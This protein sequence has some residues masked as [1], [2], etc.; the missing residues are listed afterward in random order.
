VLVY[1]A[2]AQGQARRAPQPPTE[3]RVTDKVRTE[4]DRDVLDIAVGVAQL[5]TAAVALIGIPLLI[6]QVRSAADAQRDQ[7][8]ALEAQ[9]DSV[10]QQRKDQR[11]Q[12]TRGFQEHCSSRDFL[13]KA[14]L[15]LSFLTT[16]GGDGWAADCVAKVQAWETR[17][18]AEEECLPRTPRDDA[19]PQAR[20]NDISHLMAFFE[21]FGAAYN[22][23]EL[24]KDVVIDSFAV[25]PLQ[26]FMTSWW[27]V[28]WRRKGE[29]FS[30]A[31]VAAQFEKLVRDMRRLSPVV[32]DRYLDELRGGI[33]CLPRPSR[34][35]AAER[36]EEGRRLSTLL[37]NGQ[38]RL[39]AV[40]DLTTAAAP[41]GATQW[42][43]IFVP[44]SLDHD[45][46][47]IRIYRQVKELEP[48]LAEL[49]V[50]TVERALA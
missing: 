4:S 9:R 11:S 5:V 43:L 49:D 25:I 31:A 27:F 46:R 10:E 47:H 22:H 17:S 12:R 36:W 40:L 7:R 42:Q 16:E 33:L 41:S 2:P 48:V 35:A 23:D 14:S 30:E 34:H 38:D 28:C 18:H 21:D 32:G 39:D 1:A 13:E 20:V 45:E 19:A 50:D 44:D 15:G 6:R 8:D 37:T 3:V 29:P 24:E 26:F